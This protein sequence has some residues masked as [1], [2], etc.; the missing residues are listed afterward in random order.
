MIGEGRGLRGEL[1]P[2]VVCPLP[3][4]SNRQ[5]LRTL[6]DQREKS[7]WLRDGV[8]PRWFWYLEPASL[9]P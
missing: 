4:G 8:G 5:K 9:D 3:I 6:L 2:V 7:M 1:R